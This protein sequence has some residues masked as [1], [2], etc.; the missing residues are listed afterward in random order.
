MHITGLKSAFERAESCNSQMRMAR[1]HSLGV[2]SLSW[3][4]WGE[5]CRDPSSAQ[6]GWVTTKKAHLAAS[7]FR[8]A[9]W[10]EMLRFLTRNVHE[11]RHTKFVRE[12]AKRITPWGFL[13]WHGD[14]AAG[15]KLLEIAL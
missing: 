12:H 7:F 9:G 10:V 2:Q 4:V 5:K 6:R 8:G 1:L 14:V 3:C 13:E 15:Q 11:P